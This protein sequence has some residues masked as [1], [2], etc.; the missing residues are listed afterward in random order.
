MGWES[1][2]DYSVYIDHTK[3]YRRFIDFCDINKIEQCLDLVRYVDHASFE[4]NKRSEWD[5]Q[6]KLTDSKGRIHCCDG[7]SSPGIAVVTCLLKAKGII[8]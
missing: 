1:K 4:L 8:S 2:V 6:A 3:Q 5:F 7:V